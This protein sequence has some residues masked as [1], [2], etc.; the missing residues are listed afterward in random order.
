MP[1]LEFANADGQ[2]VSILVPLTAED[3]ERHT[4]I[5]DGV[6]YKRVYA[7]PLAA[8]DT[9]RGDCKAEDYQRVTGDK[10]LTVAQ[11]AAISKEM[12][13]RRAEKN[14][15]V[16]PVKERFYETYAKEMG[17]QHQDVVVR[18]KIAAANKALAGW[19]IKINP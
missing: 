15:K 2:T 5:V 6:M 14:G 8:K 12:S 10:N 13:E 18:E 16:D 17:I 19:G 9:N 4:Q 7:A 1:V 11:A 3:H